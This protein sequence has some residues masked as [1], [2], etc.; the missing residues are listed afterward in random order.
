[1]STRRERT[2]TACL[3]RDVGDYLDEQAADLEAAHTNPRTKRVEPSCVSDE[4]R[5]VRNWSTRL[6]R[7]ALREVAP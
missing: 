4:I 7:V 3:L 1:M 5:R 6:R 2:R